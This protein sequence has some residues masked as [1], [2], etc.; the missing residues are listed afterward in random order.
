MYDEQ[1]DVYD[2]HHQAACPPLSGGMNSSFSSNSSWGEY[3]ILSTPPSTR[4]QSLDSVKVEDMSCRTPIPSRTPSRHS[5]HE[6]Y[7]PNFST[8]AQKYMSM[9]QSQDV[10]MGKPMPEQFLTCH[11][12]QANYSSDYSHYVGNDGLSHMNSF[13]APPHS[14]APSNAHTYAAHHNISNSTPPLDMDLYSP[15]SVMSSSPVSADF[16]VPSQTTFVDSFDLSSPMRPLHFDSPSS[17]Y[18]NS[19]P[20]GGLRY[21]MSPSSENERYSPTT[22]PC[23]RNPIQRQRSFQPLESSA[24]LHRVQNEARVSRKRS[25]REYMLPDNLSVQKQAKRHC[26]WPG[27]HGRFQRQEHLKRHMKTHENETKLPCQFCGKEFGRADNLKSHIKLHMDENKKSSRTV[28]FEDAKRV[29]EEMSRKSRKAVG[30]EATPKFD[31]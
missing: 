2:L 21:F 13:A 20:A 10:M 3:S 7:N 4:R 24:V 30:N 12:P 1:H 29:Y 14:L 18:E 25:K 26:T 6:M 19:S 23:A 8:M 9:L 27:C 31:N 16:V 5:V 11:T 22:T 17:D 28:Y 15:A